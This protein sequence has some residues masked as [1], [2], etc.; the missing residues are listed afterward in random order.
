MRLERG[1]LAAPAL[2]HHRIEFMKENPEL[3]PKDNMMGFISDDAGETYNLCHCASVDI[4][5]CRY[6]TTFSLE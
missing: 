1:F 6:L 4:F 3:I 5:F 2:S